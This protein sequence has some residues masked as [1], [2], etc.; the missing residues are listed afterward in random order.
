MVFFF[1]SGVAERSAYVGRL[2]HHGLPFVK[3]LSTHLPRMVNA[4]EPRRMAPGVIIEVRWGQVLS[5]GR[6]PRGHGARDGS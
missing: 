5:R 1:R 6:A 4:H 3:G 2:G